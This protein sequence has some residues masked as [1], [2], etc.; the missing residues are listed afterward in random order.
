MR[1][2]MNRELDDL[3]AQVL[4]L[5]AELMKPPMPHLDIGDL[6]EKVT[7][8][9]ADALRYRYLKSKLYWDDER[10]G[11]PGGRYWFSVF[12]KTNRPDFDAL[13]DSQA[14]PAGVE[15]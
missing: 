7:A 9:R 8:L 11:G 3:R 4:S 13:I 1:D 10:D 15:P 12:A 6:V 14:K 5:T 2:P